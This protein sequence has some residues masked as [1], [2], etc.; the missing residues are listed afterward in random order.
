MDSNRLV[1]KS[2]ALVAEKS[3]ELDSLLE[4]ENSE[5]FSEHDTF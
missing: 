2:D 3:E 1:L 5:S 4:D